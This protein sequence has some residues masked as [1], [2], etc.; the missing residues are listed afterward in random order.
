MTKINGSLPSPLYSPSANR[1]L[2]ANTLPKHLCLYEY[3]IHISLRIGKK[4]VINVLAALT[5]SYNAYLLREGT[6][7]RRKSTFV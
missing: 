4:K 2:A 3:W 1:M 7:G 5:D 6:G